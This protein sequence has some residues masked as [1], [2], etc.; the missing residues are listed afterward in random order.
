MN[1]SSESSRKMKNGTILCCSSLLRYLTEMLPNGKERSS[2]PAA[3]LLLSFRR[4]E[5][6]G[7]VK[8]WFLFCLGL[9]AHDTKLHFN[10]CLAPSNRLNS[11]LAK[12]RKFNFVEKNM[13]SI[14][15]NLGHFKHTCY[16]FAWLH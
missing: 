10:V 15:W 7:K 8:K 5:V 11:P 1:P 4:Q 9:S 6:N 3:R 16:R 2:V 12:I 14:S 13:T